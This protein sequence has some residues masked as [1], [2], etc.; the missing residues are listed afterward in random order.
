MSGL[1]M[2]DGFKEAGFATTVI[3]G[4]DGPVIDRFASVGHRTHVVPHKSWLR[5]DNALRFVKYALAE[6]FAARAL[7]R[8]LQAPA[9]DLVYVNSAV[10]IAGCIAAMRMRIPCV[11]HLR[12]LFDDVGGEMKAPGLLKPGV[13]RTFSKMA[14]RLVTNSRAVAANMLGP[15]RDRALVVPNAVSDEFFV[16]KI[17]TE[18]ARRALGIPIDGIVLGVPGTLRPMK[19]HQFLLRVLPRVVRRYPNLVVPVSGATDAPYA[20]E[21]SQECRRL[22][23]QDVVRFVGQIDDMVAFYKACDLVCIPSRAEPFGR[24]I[25]E[26]FA[27]GTPV[28]ATRVGGIPEIVDHD[29]NGILVH[30]ADDDGLEAALERLLKDSTLRSQFAV[31]AKQKALEHFANRAYTSRLISLVNEVFEASAS[32]VATSP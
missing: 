21:L 31:R 25:I 26:A 3:F 23:L 19:G 16:S 20:K 29:L 13:Q 30:F 17:D 6:W 22:G 24:T 32:E 11:W 27:T 18:E 5:T 1:L 15:W 4:H 2:A 8:T 12:E 10:S 7:G 9:S 28:I 14:L